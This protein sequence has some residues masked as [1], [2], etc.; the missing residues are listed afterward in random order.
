MKASADVNCSGTA[1][2]GVSRSAELPRSPI[3]HTKLSAAAADIFR[4]GIY[5]SSLYF[6][7]ENSEHVSS[8]FFIDQTR[9]WSHLWFI[10]NQI[11]CRVFWY[12]IQ[13]SLKT[14]AYVDY[15]P[16]SSD[17]QAVSPSNEQHQYYRFWNREIFH[18][19]IRVRWEAELSASKTVLVTLFWNHMILR[20]PYG[21]FENG[22]KYL[23]SIVFLPESVW[24]R[25]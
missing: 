4:K 3:Y 9:D 20:F 16:K 22:N 23:S 2:R 5:R 15:I 8:L 1:T 13:K 21:S 17:N 25:C 24:D 18:E 19:H 7:W 14:S 6:S 10:L 12:P 11:D